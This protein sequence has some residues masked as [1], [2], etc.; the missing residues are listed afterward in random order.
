NRAKSCGGRCL[1]PRLIQ[2]QNAYGDGAEDVRARDAQRRG[3]RGELLR[4]DGTAG[5]L[6]G[7]L[8]EG[9]VG[10]DVHAA[11][12]RHED[13]D[14]PESRAYVGRGVV[15]GQARREEVDTHCSGVGSYRL[16][17]GH[18]PVVEPAIRE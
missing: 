10:V 13:F 18:G 11:A 8:P 15:R 12:L 2:A 17:G 7:R 4:W 9:A 5:D 3:V 1:A 14:L 16:V 6:E